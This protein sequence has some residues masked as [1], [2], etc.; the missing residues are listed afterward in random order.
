MNEITLYYRRTGD[1][2]AFTPDA[3]EVCAEH[4]NKNLRVD[5]HGQFDLLPGPRGRWCILVLPSDRQLGPQALAR[6][7]DLARP[8]QGDLRIGV[9][10]ADAI[11]LYRAVTRF[12]GWAETFDPTPW[13]ERLPESAAIQRLAILKVCSA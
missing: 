12:L 8:A 3:F 10:I 5:R 6:N 9:L 13:I 4:P 11:A 1:W 2:P 7:L